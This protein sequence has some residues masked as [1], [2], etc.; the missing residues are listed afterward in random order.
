MNLRQPY[1]QLIADKLRKLPAPDAD[2]SWQQMKRLL[3]DDED[4]RAGGGKRPPGKG[5]GWWRIGIIAIILSTSLWLYVEKTTAPGTLAKNNTVTSLSGNQPVVKAGKNVSN[6]I[7]G[8][9]QTATIDNTTTLQ[10]TK[11]VTF[12]GNTKINNTTIDKP[13]MAGENTPVKGGSNKNDKKSTTLFPKQSIAGKENSLVKRNIGN[14]YSASADFTNGKGSSG[15]NRSIT[16][17]LISKNHLL[18]SQYTPVNKAAAEGERTWFDRLNQLKT[19][20]TIPTANTL[21]LTGNSIENN[22]NTTGL[23]NNETKKLV[24]K[25]QRD[26]EI[27]DLTKKEKKSFHLNLSNFFKPF[28][29]QIDAE[30]RWAAG[31]AL[32]SGITLNAQNRF[33]YNMN[34][35]S[36]TL[37]DYIPSP[38]LKFHLNDYVYMQTELN[39]ISPQYTPQLLVYQQNNDVT[40]QPGISRQKSMYI[41]KLYYFNL[42]VSLHY[43][44]INKIYFSAGLQFSSFQSGLVSIQEKQYATLSGADHPSSISSTVLKFKDD[45]IAAKLAPNEWRWQAGADYYWNRFTIGLRYNKAFKDLLSVTVSA[46]LPPTAMR[47]ESLIFFMHYNLFESRKKG[48]GDQKN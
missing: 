27:E 33:N 14:R 4:T 28:S 39:F 8:N 26:K 22:R 10:N 48:S 24:A 41:Q 34:A 7:K 1:E 15:K 21:L 23:L 19:P 32:N 2:A 16:G 17:S 3:D 47:N 40:A 31:I 5:A 13:T 35:K 44:P 25:A 12:P 29:L 20:G 36:G 43:S 42:P 45:S 9:H 6:N 11:A 37:S 38:Y 18:T 30:P 46:S